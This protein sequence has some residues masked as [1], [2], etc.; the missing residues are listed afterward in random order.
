VAK[1]DEKQRNAKVE[2]SSLEITAL[3]LGGSGALHMLL[4]KIEGQ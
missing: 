3:T 1:S 4:L 2:M